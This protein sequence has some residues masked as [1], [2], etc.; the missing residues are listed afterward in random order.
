M[1]FLLN[2]VS[3]GSTITKST[4]LPSATSCIASSKAWGQQCSHKCG[5]VVRFE[6][7]VNESNKIIASNYHA[8][9]VMTK[10]DKTNPGNLKPVLTHSKSPRPVLQEC[11]CTTLHNLASNIS[12]KITYHSLEE[13]RNMTEFKGIRSSEAFRYAALHNNNLSTKDTHCFDI[14]EEAFTAMIRGN[15]LSPRQEE[16]KDK[17]S[18]ISDDF[19]RSRILQ[20]NHQKTESEWDDFE[21]DSISTMSSSAAQ[22]KTWED[23][24]DYLDEDQVEKTA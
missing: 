3:K 16:E 19:K 23:Y 5:C 8:K 9:T 18:F 6:C 4:N 20:Y 24:I 12:N 14:V 10:H 2:S 11:S 22:F 13:V 7:E 21:D 15:M 17:M 1:R